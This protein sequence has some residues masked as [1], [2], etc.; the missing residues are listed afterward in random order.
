MAVTLEELQIKF[1][2]EIAAATSKDAAAL[3]RVDAAVRQSAQG[4]D[5]L[6]AAHATNAAAARA[7]EREQAI[8]DSQLRNAKPEEQAKRLAAAR[9]ANARAAKAAAA[10]EASA[11]RL[12]AASAKHNE[13]AGAK[14]ELVAL[15][16]KKGA[17]LAEAAAAK[18]AAAAKVAADKTA[19]AQQAAT[20]KKQAADQAAAAK[21]QAASMAAA[22]KDLSAK[23]KTAAKEEERA[24]K[25]EAAEQKSAAKEVARATAQRVA[26]AKKI[27]DQR[28]ASSEDAATKRIEASQAAMLGAAGAALAFAAAVGGATIAAAGLGLKAADAARSARLLADA[29]TGSKELGAEFDAV[30][31]QL[32]SKVP[33][34]RTQIADLARELNLMKLGRRDMQA[35][36]TAIAITTSAIG[37]S[38]GNV[39]KGVVQSSAAMKRFTLG[40]RDMWGE[41]TGLAGSGLKSADVLAALAKE[42]GVS[43]KEVEK[44]L[45][46][47][48]IGIKTGMR[49][50]EAAAQA[51]FGKTIEAQMLSINTQFSKAQENLAQMTSGVDL[52][53][54]LNGLKELLS[55]FD[56]STVSGSV[57]KD[58]LTEGLG[59]LSRALGVLLPL[60]KDF[61]LEFAIGA[62]EIYLALRPIG[63]QILEWIGPLLTAQNAAQTGRIAVYAL[64]AVFGVLAVA[65]GAAAFAILLPFALAGL[66]IWGLVT[67]VQMAW[68]A[69]SEGAKSAAGFIIE[70]LAAGIF[71]GIPTVVSAIA[72]LG[73][74]VAEKFRSVLKIRSPSKVFFGYGVNIGEGAEDGIEAS[75][76]GVQDAVDDMAPTPAGGGS[77]GFARA[78]GG[79]T[80]QVHIEN[81]Y[82]GGQKAT[83]QEAMSVA[84]AIRQLLQSGMNAAGA[85]EPLGVPT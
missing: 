40:A 59:G 12:G 78:G 62:M 13:L 2:S 83:E 42:L 47:G 55:I 85:G 33:L 11:A 5:K 74:A 43:E 50:L 15:A 22:R 84:E 67:V 58:I 76:S 31:T 54:A 4:L 70:G 1:K 8:A 48:A 39:V 34:A 64:A 66:A 41:Y 32:A 68:G 19:A 61:F 26:A 75:T 73:T 49:A 18:Q 17:M 81:L 38:A 37:E 65:A 71:G 44:K 79:N 46:I 14:P 30:V 52:E 29:L 7:A 3:A 57:L 20:T 21:Q 60:G 16:Q 9:A 69:L 23:L 51:R 45:R 82:L 63:R 35:G 25:R 6:R 10:E 53:P 36:L 72:N 77:G 28:K 24:A 27:E 56:E 80:Y